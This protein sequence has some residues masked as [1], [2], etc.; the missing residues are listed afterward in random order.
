MSEQERPHTKAE[1]KDT[2]PTA[3]PPETIP[4]PLDGAEEA[5]REEDSAAGQPLAEESKVE[6]PLGKESQTEK[7][8]ADKPLAEQPSAETPSVETPEVPVGRIDMRQPLVFGRGTGSVSADDAQTLPWTQGPVAQPSGAPQTFAQA[9]IGGAQ[10]TVAD[11]QAPIAVAQPVS[12][13]HMPPYQATRRDVPVEQLSRRELGDAGERMA[14][15]YLERHGYQILMHQYRCPEGEAD[16]V[17]RMGRTLV[18]VEVKTRIATRGSNPEELAPETAVDR[19]KQERYLRMAMTL[20]GQ[21]AG[22]A[23]VRFDVIG[24]SVL[25]DH[26]ARL[27][28]YV[29]A[30]GLGEL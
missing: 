10:P 11:P 24:I 4:E 20:R 5:S 16:I 22:V 28:H 6:R 2:S 21:V 19:S 15:T 18:L 14:I 23:G 26:H 25:G 27:R 17:A 8:L 30:F 9:P 12:T 29:D 7:P 13:P 1:H 3:A